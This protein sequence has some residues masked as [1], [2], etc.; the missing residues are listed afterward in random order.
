MAKPPLPDAV[1]QKLA[2][3]PASSGCY[4]FKDAAQAVVYVGKAKSLRSRVR[5]YFAKSRSD[6]RYFIPLLRRLVA[7]VETV[8]TNTEK[9]AAVLEND[10]IKK[11]QPR[12]NAKLRDDKDFLCLR[13]DEKKRWPRL[14]TVRRPSADGAR[15][16]GP[17][18][19]ATSARRTLHLVNKHFQLRT[20]TDSEL[21]SRKRACL[22]YQIKRCPAPCV[23]DVDETHYAQQVRSVALFLNARH[24]ELTGELKERMRRAS[25]RLEYELA[26][27]YRDQLRAVESIRQKQRVVTVRRVDQDVVA[28][29]RE[30][31]RSEL[32]MMLVR[33]GHVTDSQSFS[34]AR[35]ELPDAEILAGFLG[36]YYGSAVR[37]GMLPD[38][39]VLPLRPDAVQGLA[40]WLSEQRG[41]KVRVIVP[42]AGPRRH[43]LQLAQDNAAH[44]FREKQRAGDEI[45]ARLEQL[46]HKLRLST[47]PR[48][49]ECC[50]ISHHQGSDTIGAVVCLRDG[51]PYKKRYRTFKV[52]TVATGDDY[53]A[54]YEVLARRFRRGRTACDTNAASDGNAGEQ[55]PSDWELPDLFVV[56]GGRGQLNVALTAARDLGLHDLAIVGLAKER[57]NR[58]GDKLVDRVYLP[59]QKNGIAL[60]PTS[61]A[62]Y[63]LAHA[64]DEAH[65]FANKGRKARGKKRQLRSEL[66]GIKG[67]GPVARKALLT[68][69][70]SMTA[71]RKASDEQILAIDGVSKRHLTALRKVVAAPKAKGGATTTQSRRDD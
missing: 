28:L 21:R 40:D 62:L 71:I 22:Q 5:S 7:D 57:E 13:L 25:E 60:R 19:S 65:R 27:L 52:N 36:Q 39:I 33:Q 37:L 18:H 34:M 54:M 3:L 46:R 35:S 67:V 1:Q 38:E 12:F 48:V 24:D 56:D 8:V 6:N 68:T 11:H 43:L 69:L 32:V 63:L 45:E 26:G 17:Y 70:G 59:G 15:Y 23:Y 2:G 30:G 42:K 66:D 64:R 58:R 16:F 14:E 61:A 51:R 9:E 44:A 41:K 49:I 50:D 31:E 4:L 10:L 47:L 55:E 53:N 20:C 29:Y